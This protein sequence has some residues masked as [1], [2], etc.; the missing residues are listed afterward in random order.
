VGDGRWAALMALVP[1]PILLKWAHDARL[2]YG[3]VP[4]CTLLLLLLLGLRVVERAATPAQR[5]RAVLVAGLVAGLA[6]W[7][8][9]IHTI[10]IVAVAGMILVRRPRLRPAALAV[11]LAFVGSASFWVFAAVRGRLAPIRTPL[12]EPAALPEQAHLLLTHALPLLLGLPPRALVGAAGPV[13]VA[14]GLIVLAAALGVCVVRGGVSGWLVAGVVVLGSAA[15]VVAEHGKRLGGDEPLYLIPVV[16]VLPVALGVLLAHVGRR[17]R[18]AV[19]ALALALLGG[20]VAGLR[21]AYPRLF[22]MREWQSS[23]QQTRWPLGA[24]E[25]LT[26]AGQTAVYTHDPDV[27]TFASAERIT[28]SHLYQERYPPLA[29][30]VDAAPR[31]AYHSATVPPGFD[32]SLAAAG[33]AWT[34]AT[35]P[36]GWPHYSDFRLEHDG[37]REIRTDGWTV[38]ASHQSGLVPHTIDR[39]ARTHWEARAGRDATIWVQIDLGVVHEV[40]MVAMLPRTFQEVPPG[41]G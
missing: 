21:A 3:L 8:N 4:A 14:G 5:T 35:S 13:L 32:R 38:S 37:H 26:A 25:R 19:L 41:S 23:R 20:H 2:Y 1:T 16:A 17:S 39:D 31:V 29:D 9:L 28:V 11:P 36:L 27:L 34:V 22:S 7:T 18:L 12:A 30:R 15:V 10:P 6:W 24:V 33:I 40:G